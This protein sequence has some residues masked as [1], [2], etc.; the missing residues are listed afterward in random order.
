MKIALAETIQKADK[1]NSVNAFPATP[2]C[3]FALIELFTSAHHPLR[4]LLT[5]ALVKFIAHPGALCSGTE[6]G[7]SA[8]GSY[9]V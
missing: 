9:H 6:T 1:N 3:L 7:H 4:H 5:T 8:K 2:P